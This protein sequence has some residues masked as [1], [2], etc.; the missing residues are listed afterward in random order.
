MRRTWQRP[1]RGL[2]GWGWQ[3]EERLEDLE[4]TAGRHGSQIAALQ[5][6]VRWGRYLLGIAAALVSGAL[7]ATNP[8]RWGE[9][10]AGLL[11]AVIGLF[12]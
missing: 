10:V 1:P 3:T 2:N 8:E 9:A 5:V 12:S 11:K 4:R 7:M 6:L